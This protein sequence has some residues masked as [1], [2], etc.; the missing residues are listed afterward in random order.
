MVINEQQ[1]QHNDK[2]VNYQVDCMS[3]KTGKLQL[4][5]A[6]HLES[7]KIITF[8]LLLLS[9]S[10]NLRKI[11][12]GMLALPYPFL[13]PFPFP[14]FTSLSFPFPCHKAAP[15]NPANDLGCCKI[16]QL[17]QDRYPAAK[18]FLV[19]FVLP[20]NVSSGNNFGTFGADQSVSIT[21]NHRNCNP[22]S[23]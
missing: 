5:F 3:Q 18:A 6:M 21:L 8:H 12:T 13:P 14:V 7:Y 22:E 19:Y 10:P 11:S 1:K 17:V 23:G 2:L 15:L 16:F 4:Q 9:S 20:G